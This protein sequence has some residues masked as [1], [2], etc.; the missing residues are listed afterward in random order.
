MK[1]N[2]PSPVT[3]LPLVAAP[4]NSFKSKELP[5]LYK[6]RVFSTLSGVAIDAPQ[7]QVSN[8]ASRAASPI[9]TFFL[10]IRAFSAF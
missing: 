7:A 9:S 3:A 6:L 8:A 1:E 10:L 2:A 4:V 5:F